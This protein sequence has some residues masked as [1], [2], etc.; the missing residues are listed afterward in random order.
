[1]E[2][3]SLKGRS[4]SSFSQHYSYVSLRERAVG[5]TDTRPGHVCASGISDNA[6]DGAGRRL[7]AGRADGQEHHEEELCSNLGRGL[8]QRHLSQN[9][10]VILPLLPQLRHQ[11]D[12]AG[13]LSKVIQI[14]IPLEQRVAREPVL[15]RR[16]QPLD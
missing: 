13:I 8:L 1:M 11:R 3:Y 16:R 14:A 5:E 4:A 15:S 12:E 9:G 10:P 6:G 7:G 2:E